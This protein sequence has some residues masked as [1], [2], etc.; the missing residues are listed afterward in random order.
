MMVMVVLVEMEVRYEMVLAYAAHNRLSHLPPLVPHPLEDAECERR[1]QTGRE[2]EEG[3]IDVR[4][5][6]AME[7]G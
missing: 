1:E 7:G 3:R 5:P 2:D 4:E 6:R